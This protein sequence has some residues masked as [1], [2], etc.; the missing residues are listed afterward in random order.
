MRER[1]RLLL[2]ACFYYS[3]LIRLA[4]WW[5][6]RSKRHLIILNYHRADGR[7]L[8]RQ[9]LFLHR[10]FRVLR[11]EDAL[12]EFY[13]LYQDGKQ[14]RD[15]R[16]PLVLTFDDGYRDNYTYGFKVA[17]ELGVP[18]TV[19]LIPGYVE[20]GNYFWWLE[21]KRL[22][23]RAQVDEVTLEEQIYC[24]K[25]EK[26]REALSKLIDTHLRHAPSVQVREEFLVKMRKR[27]SVPTTVTEEEEGALPLTWVQIREMEE[28]G[29]VSFGAHT[30]HHPI[31]SSLVDTN[32]VK[33]ELRECREVLEQHLEH[34]INCLAYPVGK[35]E[36]FGNI[37][38]HMAKEEGYTWAFTTIEDAC[39]PDSD[40]Y[41][42]PR[43][44]ADITFHWL[45]M[46]AY[47]AGLLGSLSRIRKKDERISR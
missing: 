21:G 24:L 18:F 27:L 45:I 14:L 1:V 42:L 16:L 15:R 2:A 38:L 6:R 4:L 28:S 3:G 19:F 35:F 26:D 9:M 11:L 43:V 30:M 37:G 44:A 33:Q 23:R 12:M 40:P 8:R 47:L 31:L 41:L 34:P 29:L 39:T 13:T 25:Q 10:H 5:Q 46:A 32:E 36:H 7:N 17:K 22:V 20:S